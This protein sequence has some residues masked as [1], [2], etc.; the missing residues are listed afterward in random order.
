M[1]SYR[2]SLLVSCCVLAFGLGGCG[3]PADS[4]T[5]EPAAS[6]PAAAAKA[7][8][9]RSAFGTL[10]D[11]TGV[12]LF[13]LTNS[14]GMEVRVINYGGIVTAL[15]V[16]DRNG[17]LDDVVLGYD[18]LAGYVKNP[19]YLG[20][21]VGR[22]ANRIGK[23]QFTLDGKT[24]QLAANNDGNSLH[25]GI[26]GFDKAVWQAESFEKPGQV[27]VVLT[28]TSPDGEEGYPGNLAARVTYTLSDAN[29]LSFDYSATTDKPTVLNLTHHDY[30]NLAGDGSG[31]V[32]GHRM[33]I[34]ADRYT[35]VDATLLPLGDLA[36]VAGTPFDF[37]SLTPIGGRIDAD[38]PQIKLGAGY[39]HN[40]VINHQGNDLALA[41]RVQEPK[42]GRVME[43]RT[44]EPG[45]QFYSANHLDGFT[46]KAGH[47]YNKRNAFCLETQHYPDSPNKSAFPTTTLRPSEEFHSRTVYAFSAH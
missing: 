18:S 39:D 2:L 46:G 42:S 36:T 6:A 29:E 33:Q 24:Y 7:T 22:Y 25:G 44:T 19:A 3:K 27:G 34:N 9:T 30:F 5:S 45:V 12:E 15:K 17:K 47:I 41:A 13:T 11:G 23:A 1:R 43:V 8:V 10:P 38:S 20:A 4:N 31:D 32:L 28:H 14:S 40:F 21:L 35:P 37:R 26:K 16:P